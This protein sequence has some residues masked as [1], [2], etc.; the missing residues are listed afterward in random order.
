MVFILGLVAQAECLGCGC[1]FV[2][3]L[4]PIG[5]QVPELGS[6]DLVCWKFEGADVLEGLANPRQPLRQRRAE[7]PERRD[8]G[9]IRPHGVEW[10]VE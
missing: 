1:E 10:V 3:G 5:F 9:G 6:L 8:A 7:R 4:T 2:E